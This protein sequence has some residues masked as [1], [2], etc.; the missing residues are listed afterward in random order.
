MNFIS[1]VRDQNA[2]TVT[3]LSKYDLRISDLG[4]YTTRFSDGGTFRFEY[5][6]LVLFIRSGGNFF[7]MPLGLTYEHP[8]VIV[9]PD[10]VEVRL[11]YVR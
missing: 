5:Q 6:G 1:S 7:L 3:V 9:I 4:V 2:P 10:K 8:R 11:Y